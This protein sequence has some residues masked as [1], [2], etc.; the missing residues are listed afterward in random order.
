MR[1]KALRFLWLALVIV[2]AGCKTTPAPLPE[3]VTLPAPVPNQALVITATALPQA[4][5]TSEPETPIGVIPTP[6]PGWCNQLPTASA[7]PEGRLRVAFIKDQD[8]WIWNK[9]QPARQLT[10]QGDVEQV[11]LSDDGQAVAY[12]RSGAV[13]TQE[14]WWVR[15]GGRAARAVLSAADFNQLRKEPEQ[16]GVIPFNL[17]WIPGTHRLA[18]NTYP[19]LPGEDLWIYVPDDLWAVDLDSLDLVEL[20]PKGEG[21][22]FSFS[23]DGELAA[24][25]SPEALMIINEEGAPMRA[26]VLEGFQAIGLG[27]YY[28]YPSLQWSPD[29]QTLLAA[30]PT[31]TDPFQ[32]QSGLVIWKIPVGGSEPIQVKN[33]PAYLSQV[34]FSPDLSRMAYFSQPELRSS[35]RELHL[36]QLEGKED[37]LF[38]R[39]DVLERFQWLPD[40][41]HF[42]YWVADTWQPQF[43]HICQDAAEFPDFPV[44]SDIYWVDATRFLFL[45]GEEGDWELN[46]GHLTGELTPIAELGESSAFAFSVVAE[47]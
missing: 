21:G 46:L 47:E 13:H 2:L 6:R 26:D 33:I 3:L 19:L 12:L 23:P 1:I 39:G 44:R 20:L 32:P 7:A 5:L 34:A 37:F 29:S 25:F 9:G 36:S 18:F 16:V 24:V 38:L 4:L 31:T 41:Q 45:S 42:L 10:R 43:G 35:G 11:Y 28:S 40:S 8:V 14:L 22:H 15:A 17:S 30:I 27:E